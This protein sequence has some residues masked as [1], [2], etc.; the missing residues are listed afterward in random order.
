ME[1]YSIDPR[2]D[3]DNRYDYHA[4]HGD[5]AGR[6]EEIRAKCK[7]LAQF[8]CARTPY[9]REQSEAL[10]CL[11]GVMFNANAAI[12]R[13]EPQEGTQHADG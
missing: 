4:P 10:T 7:E 3:L 6:Y 2:L 9:S 13:N 5:Q 12:A 8:I 11:D 1:K